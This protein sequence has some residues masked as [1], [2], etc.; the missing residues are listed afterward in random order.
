LDIIY[1]R[2]TGIDVQQFTSGL[3]HSASKEIPP[4]HHGRWRGRK[5]LMEKLKPSL[6]AGER[7]E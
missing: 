7:G 5:T 6:P 3:A 2:Q 1:P 4:A